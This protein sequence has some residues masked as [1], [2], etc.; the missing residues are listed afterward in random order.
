VGVDEGGEEEREEAEDWETEG[1][2]IRGFVRAWDGELGEAVEGDEREQDLA[3][4]SNSIETRDVVGSDFKYAKFLSLPFF[5]CGMVDLPP[6]GFKRA[7]NARKMQMVFFVHMGKVL[8]RVG[9]AEFTIS[10]GGVWHV[11]RGQSNI[12][13]PLLVFSF[14]TSAHTGIAHYRV[15]RQ[16]ALYRP[17]FSCS[18]MVEE[19]PEKESV[20]E[21]AYPI[22]SVFL[23]Y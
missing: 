2:V 22:A 17:S 16:P 13:F 18:D 21:D 9:E 10:K 5:G 11:P 3:F 7:K 23:S 19:E 8:V 14:R 20:R 15:V 6:G 4:S 12:S 1:G